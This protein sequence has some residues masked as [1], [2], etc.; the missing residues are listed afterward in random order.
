MFDINEYFGNIPLAVEAQFITFKQ[1]SEISVLFGEPVNEGE[2]FPDWFERAYLDNKS[3]IDSNIPEGFSGVFQI[4]RSEESKYYYETMSVFTT[5]DDL[6]DAK[7]LAVSKEKELVDLTIEKCNIEFGKRYSISVCH[8]EEHSELKVFEG[9][10]L[11]KVDER[12]LGLY[13]EGEAT[14]LYCGEWDGIPEGTNIAFTINLA[15][16]NKHTIVPVN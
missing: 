7:L 1:G 14:E 12:G 6:D 4:V 8:F 11:F 13:S 5:D 16:N 10:T 2:T 9:K 15:L 3:G